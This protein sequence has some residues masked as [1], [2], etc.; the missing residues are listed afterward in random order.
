MSV[1]DDRVPE[2]QR[3]LDNLS[4]HWEYPKYKGD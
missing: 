1:D 4:K 3:L 2:A